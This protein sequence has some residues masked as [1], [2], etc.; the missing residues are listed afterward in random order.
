MHA[1]HHFRS[2]R[3]LILAALAIAIAALLPLSPAHAATL[4]I[5]GYVYWDANNNGVRDAGEAGVPGIRVRHGSGQVSTITAADGSY[6]LAGLPTTGNVTVE[7]GWLR[8]QCPD[9][10]RSTAITCPAGPGRDNAFEVDNQFIRYPL[11]G[12]S[13]ATYV[14]VGLLPDWPGDV[15]VPPAGRVPANSVDVAARLSW[16]TGTCTDDSWHI[17]RPG[18]TFV[19]NAQVFN[20]GVT[21]LSGIVAT[22]AVPAGDCLTGLSLIR[23]ATAPDVTAMSTNPSTLSCVTGTVTVSLQ[24]RLVPAGAAILKVT[25]STRSGPGTP[26]CVPGAPVAPCTTAEP[27]GRAWLFAVS[28]IDQP[29][30]PDST[31]CAAGNPTRCPTGLHDKRRNPD[32]VDPVGHNVIASLAGTTAIDLQTFATLLAPTGPV[33]PGTTLSLRT[34]AGNQLDGQPANQINPGAT[35]TLYLPPGTTVTPPPKHALLS[36]AVGT[37]V[38]AVLVTCTNKGPLSPGLSGVAFTIG[39]TVPAGWPT[40]TVFPAVAC[41]APPAAQASAERVPAAACGLATDPAATPTNNDAGL[42][43]PVT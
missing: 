16:V 39:V 5:S 7:T 34:W 41:G 10:S 13:S 32:E 12:R 26:G 27:Q 31:F 43:I 22:L 4:Q 40:G 14:N 23:S 17:C 24:G 6:T 18:D 25:G 38:S 36:C 1:V 19:L 30:D 42:A 33:H 37:Q 20:Q 21:P 2:A 9:P 8:S 11:A 28:H 29:G 15:L 35:V 3:P